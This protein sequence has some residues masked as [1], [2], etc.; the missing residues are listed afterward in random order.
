MLLALRLGRHQL[1]PHHTHFFTRIG[2]FFR[3]ETSD[4]I[5]E[6]A[7]FDVLVLCGVRLVLSLILL[8]CAQKHARRSALSPLNAHVSRG[9]GWAWKAVV[10]LTVLGV[11]YTG[12]CLLFCRVVLC[13]HITMCVDCSQQFSESD[14]ES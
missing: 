14:P 8:S 5:Y 6:T 1:V 13:R 7:V 3:S 10:L 4:F 11:M 12:V 9:V 2:F